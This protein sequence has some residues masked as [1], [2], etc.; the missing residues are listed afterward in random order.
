MTQD[1]AIILKLAMTFG[2][3]S[4][5]SVGGAPAMM[6]EIHRLTVE[7][8]GWLTNAEFARD[9]AISQT[10]PGPNFM[11]IS[12]V[13]WRVAGMVGLLA[14]TLA[15]IIP[16]SILAIIV[17]RL[18]TRFS[19]MAWF[20]VVKAALPPIVL[21]LIVASGVVTARAAVSGVVGFLVVIGSA[22]FVALS[23]RNPLYAIAGGVIV[24]I[25]AGRLGLI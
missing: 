15:A 18:Y 1:D 9:F 21:G 6:P 10:A 22:T 17:G 7:L 20:P 19:L 23:R 14:A 5:V 12:L 11:M 3:L 16:S 25:L 8:H 24:G 2:A 13:G 4:L